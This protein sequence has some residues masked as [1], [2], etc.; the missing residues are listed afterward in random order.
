MINLDSVLK[1][2]LYMILKVHIFKETFSSIELVCYLHYFQSSLKNGNIYKYFVYFKFQIK[3]FTT[4]LY[5]AHLSKHPGLVLVLK[6]LI[7]TLS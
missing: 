3:V 6:V 4:N 5:P 7:Y 1:Y 2:D